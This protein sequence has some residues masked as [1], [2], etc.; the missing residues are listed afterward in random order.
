MIR[1]AWMLLL[2]ILLCPVLADAT[3][4]YVRSVEGEYGA[5]DGSNY[6]NAFDGFDDVGALAAGDTL[7]ICGAH[8]A[9]RFN[10]ANGTAGTSTSYIKFDFR[11][12]NDPGSIRSVWPITGATTAVNWTE[13]SANKWSISTAAYFQKSMGRVWLDGVEQPLSNSVANLGTVIDGV[14]D[15]TTAYSDSGNSKLYLY[16]TANPAT[17]YT[18]FESLGLPSNGTGCSY[19]AICGS[20]ATLKYLEFIDPVLEGGNIAALELDGATDIIIRGTATDGSTCQIGKDSKDGIKIYDTVGDGSGTPTA[21]WTIRYCTFNSNFPFLHFG[22]TSQA[23]NDGIYFFHN[24]S[25]HVIEHNYFYRWLHAAVEILATQNT[26]TA[27]NNIIRNNYVECVILSYCRAFVVDGAALGDAAYNAFLSNEIVGQATRS[28]INGDHNI[29][30]GNLWRDAGCG[31]VVSQG[32]DEACQYLAPEAYAGDIGYNVYTN[33]TFVNNPY[34]PCFHVYTNA[35]ASA[36]HVITNNLF[37]NCGG[38]NLTGY[39]NVGFATDTTNITNLT[40]KN[41]HIYKS[42]VSSNVRYRGTNMTVAAMEAAFSGGDSGS[43]NVATDP[44][45]L[46]TSDFRLSALST[47]RRA[48]ISGYPCSD[49]RGRACYPDRPDIGAYQATSRDPAGPRTAR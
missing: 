13:E 48:G 15:V 4:Y 26:N 1:R 5:E 32:G 45:F 17:R 14:G 16:S 31:E 23:L 6:T 49:V 35:N 41:N 9:T 18:T 10:I 22:H 20:S 12:P 11:C 28:Q 24:G 7:Y 44:L 3:T 43:G 25:G 19:S 46:S 27:T 38:T 30:S 29:V 40:I 42:G 36:G 39:D 37:I 21:R 33:N 34:M 47:A 8:T 2:V